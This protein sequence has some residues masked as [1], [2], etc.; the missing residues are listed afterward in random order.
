MS[1]PVAS[2]EVQQAEAPRPENPMRTVRI[3]KVVLHIGV[4]TSGERLEKAAR[5][6]EQLSGQKPS[7]RKAKKTIKGFGIH[8]GEPIAAMVTLRGRKALEMLNRL[9][10]ARGRRIPE[11]SFDGRGN[12]SF[13]I[14]EHIDIPGVKY[15]PEIGIF[16]M[17]VSVALSRPGYRVA[18]RRR[19]RSYVGRDHV[20]SREDAIN[21]FRTQLNVEVVQEI[22]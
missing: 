16:G 19:A 9:L 8:R 22:G 21:F 17:D 13:G 14:K 1:E 3:E 20:V 6:L 2:A 12:V 15:D 10:D 18:R 4:G 11:S 5:L 7:I